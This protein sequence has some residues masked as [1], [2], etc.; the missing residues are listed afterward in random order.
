MWT[1]R[2][3]SLEVKKNLAGR[4]LL[5]SVFSKDARCLFITLGKILICLGGLS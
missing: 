3:I 5:L 4:I 1:Q 2:R